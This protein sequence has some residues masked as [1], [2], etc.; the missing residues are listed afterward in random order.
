MTEAALI[1]NALAII[2]GFMNMP[3]FM[4]ILFGFVWTAFFWIYEK[5][6]WIWYEKVLRNETNEVMVNVKIAH[7]VEF[8]I[9]MVSVYVLAYLKKPELC[10]VMPTIQM[11]AAHSVRLYKQRTNRNIIIFF[12]IVIELIFAIYFAMR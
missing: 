4:Y 12:G 9:V 8:I 3:V 2:C 6:T 7:I 1:V 11:L 5:L 10:A